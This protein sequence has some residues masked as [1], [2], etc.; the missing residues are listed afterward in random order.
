LDATSGSFTGR[1]RHGAD[2]E[3]TGRLIDELDALVGLLGGKLWPGILIKGHVQR[4]AD[5]PRGASSLNNAVAKTQW[6]GSH[7]IGF[8]IQRG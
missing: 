4:F 1:S 5:S 3:G 7:F 6:L 2:C 8:G